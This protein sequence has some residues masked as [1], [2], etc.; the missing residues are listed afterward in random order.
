MV[1]TADHQRGPWWA[2]MLPLKGRQKPALG[3]LRRQGQEPRE[4]WGRGAHGS[5]VLLCMLLMGTGASWML[6]N[7]MPVL[8]RLPVSFSFSPQG[9]F[10]SVVSPCYPKYTAP[11]MLS[12]PSRTL[13]PHSL[14]L[15]SAAHLLALHPLPNPC[16][17]S[18]HN[19][20]H[21]LVTSSSPG[22][23]SA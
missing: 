6:L 21:F 5:S 22:F 23:F 13:M 9:P 1:Y 14:R 12:I 7:D 2:A 15:P 8:P 11:P 16:P 4:D 19:P 18:S 17:F 10:L 3:W 20:F